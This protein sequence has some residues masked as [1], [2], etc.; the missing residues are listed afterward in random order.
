M[1]QEAFF[2][3]IDFSRSQMLHSWEARKI[4]GL[5]TVEE[6]RAQANP[7]KESKRTV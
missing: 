6:N 3:R 4:L 1:S 7:P 2:T 5:Q